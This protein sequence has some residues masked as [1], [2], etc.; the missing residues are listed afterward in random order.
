LEGNAITA[1]ET[2]LKDLI[3]HA[4]ISPN[5]IKIE[6]ELNEKP[7]VLASELNIDYR[8]TMLAQVANDPQRESEEARIINEIKSLRK[9]KL[10][11]IS[12]I[13]TNAK[14]IK[15]KSGA[16]KAELEKVINDLKILANAPA[17]SAE[18]IV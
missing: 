7:R 12:E 5:I 9:S 14:N 1:E 17:D 10:T 4:K 11:K 8:A 3:N 2:R 6:A 16:T 18:Q 13:I 15:D